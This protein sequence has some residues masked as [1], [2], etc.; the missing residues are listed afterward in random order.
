MDE[1]LAIVEEMIFSAP[2]D[3]DAGAKKAKREA[4]TAATLPKY[5]DHLEAR[6]S[7]SGGPILLGSALSV[8]DLAVFGVMHGL[9]H[10]AFDYVP[11]SAALGRPALF[12]LSMA[13][14]AL[15][16]VQAELAK[17]KH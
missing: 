13:V 14:K 2:Q 12:A 16:D 4:W 11:A 9:T 3:P 15:P 10:G 5:L 6:A 7:A 17:E 8:A 1:S